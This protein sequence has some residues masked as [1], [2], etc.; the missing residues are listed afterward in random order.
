MLYI[1]K[2]GFENYAKTNGIQ[3]TIKHKPMPF[4]IKFKDECLQVFIAYGNF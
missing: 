2:I 1:G 4:S 3:A